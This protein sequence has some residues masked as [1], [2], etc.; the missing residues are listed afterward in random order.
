MPDPVSS[1]FELIE[2]LFKALTLDKGTE[3]F[4]ESLSKQPESRVNLFAAH[5]CLAEVHNGGFL[6]FLWNS[7]GILLPEAVLGFTAIEMPTIAALVLSAAQPLGSPYPR[8]RDERWDA[9]LVASGHSPKELKRIFKNA[10]N[11]YPG[12]EEATRTLHFDLLDQQFWNA[13]KTENGGFQEAATRYAQ[14]LV[15]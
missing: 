7:T 3:A 11:L 13:A 8:D 15:K 10:E 2:P 14:S 12:F 5:M 9:L 4:H 1:Y 6:Q